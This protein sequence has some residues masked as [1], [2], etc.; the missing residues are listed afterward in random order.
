MT[1]FDELLNK[2]DKLPQKI[3]D[4]LDDIMKGN[5]FE[6]KVAQAVRGQLNAGKR[7]DHTN[8]DPPY[9]PITIEKKKAK[10]QRT[11]VVTLR[12]EGQFQD[13]IQLK[14][15]AGRVEIVSTDEK[16]E[17]LQDKYGPEILD[18]DEENLEII[19][20]DDVKPQLIRDVKQYL[21]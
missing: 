16:S 1:P 12:D 14:E 4:S 8:I 13:H 21:S 3:E 19:T 10:G 5:V 15:Y 7:G 11:D 18:I 6:N 9:K 20:Q 2:L 17:G